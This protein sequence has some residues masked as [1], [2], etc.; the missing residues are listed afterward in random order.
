MVAFL[1]LT[2]PVAACHQRS[3]PTD[4]YGDPLPPGALLRLGTVRFRPEH[5]GPYKS[6][7][8]SPDGNRLVS[9]SG[10]RA[11]R[12]WDIASG[13]ELLRLECA[14]AGDRCPA[15]AWSPD[16][17]TLAVGGIHGKSIGVVDALTGKDIF[18]LTG[19]Q[20]A[21]TVLAW[22]P[23]GKKLASQAGD[24]TV[25]LWNLATKQE[26][27]QLKGHEV[28]SLSLA[29]AWSPDGKILAL[30]G[31]KTILLRDAATGRELLR[32]TG[33]EK[34]IDSLAWSPDGKMLASGSGDKTIRIWEMETGKALCRFASNGANVDWVAWSSDSKTLISG[35]CQW[36]AASGK[37]LR[38]LDGLSQAVGSPDGTMLASWGAS[39]IQLWDAATGNEIRPR[40]G[41]ESDILT[42]AWSSD[43]KLL[44][45]G[46]G[47]KTIRLWDT[48]T[49][50]EVRHFAVGAD[51][52]TSVAWS[53]DG[54][55]LASAIEHE[56]LGIRLWN[57]ATGEQIGEFET[58]KNSALSSV[59]WSPDGKSLA[60][61]GTDEIRIWDVA[62]GKEIR[63]FYPAKCFVKSVAWSPDGRTLAAASA[64]GLRLWDVPTGIEMRHYS[65]QFDASVR[66][67]AWSPDG[68]MLAVAWGNASIGIWT[69]ATGQKTQW[70]D[71]NPDVR[72]L[73]WSAD[74]KML[75]SANGAG[76]VKIWDVPTWTE[77]VWATGQGAS[78][79][80]VAFSPDGGRLATAS[81]NTTCL[82]WDV[83]ALKR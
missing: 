31:E 68:K 30:G 4:L 26:I 21:A 77:T 81:H 13:K 52:V 19:H 34:R 32:L 36:E 35:G 16:G 54:K 78:T 23:D 42:V 51:S 24:G 12:L 25:R 76:V 28:F 79:K 7:I 75:A 45:T 82:I 70:L 71:G 3:T 73:T 53:P 69:A 9:S 43:G 66:H 39:A 33:H 56:N 15:V 37:Q 59:C 8:W 5:S 57:P 58:P 64:E 55:T 14:S 10:D 40:S 27:L 20:Y 65:G 46:G 17:K 38:R 47:E 74:G 2:I 72:S 29:L 48:V 60:A 22:S 1:A 62:A 44:A 61:G 18:H 63:R 6:L 80:L 83:A 67:V 50:K 41:H 11:I 49:G